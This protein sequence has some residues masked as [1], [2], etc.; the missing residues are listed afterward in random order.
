LGNATNGMCEKPSRLAG[1]GF[2]AE[3]EAIQAG[4]AARGKPRKSVALIVCLRRDPVAADR[5]S[6]EG[7]AARLLQTA[8]RATA[9]RCLAGARKSAFP[10][11]GLPPPHRP[12]EI[13]AVRGHRG[14]AAGHLL[15]NPER[16]WT[17]RCPHCPRKRTSGLAFRT[18]A[19]APLRHVSHIGD[20]PLTEEDRK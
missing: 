6:V 20:C 15:I 12:P 9:P 11:W 13:T 17:W 18:S 16:S 3:I 7:A 14:A 19:L 10:P 2:R 8:T 1:F 4:D 5:S